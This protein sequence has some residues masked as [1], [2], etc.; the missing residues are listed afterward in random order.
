MKKIY[1]NGS[2]DFDATISQESAIIEQQK[3]KNETLQKE[4]SELEQFYNETYNHE[5][6]EITEADI[7]KELSFL[8]DALRDQKYEVYLKKYGSDDSMEE[9]QAYPL[10]FSEHATYDEQFARELADE[11]FF[12]NSNE[13]YVSRI[14]KDGQVIYSENLP[15]TFD[16]RELAQHL[17]QKFGKI[18]AGQ[19]ARRALGKS[20]SYQKDEAIYLSEKA[21][22]LGSVKELYE[23][24]AP[25]VYPQR[26]KYLAE[27]L[28]DYATEPDMSEDLFSTGLTY[29]EAVKLLQQAE[30]GVTVKEI[31]NY[32]NDW[33][34]QDI[35]LV[36]VYALCYFLL[37]FGKEKG[38]QIFEEK[39][40][41]PFEKEQ[42]ISYLDYNLSSVHSAKQFVE[43]I[44][45]EN[46]T[47]E[48]SQLGS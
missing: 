12:P 38:V 45:Q 10:Y 24:A 30:N 39:F 6:F 46:N 18:F 11:L 21:D 47:Y 9:K 19:Y 25:L 37:I 20:K 33:Q 48:R 14:V 36:D 42:N 4:N 8:R 13:H 5:F 43:Q 31:L 35:T 17:E 22:L 34:H 27:F 3:Q 40:I 26:Q 1:K 28:L 32:I 7:T 2:I 15:Q 23:K 29:K 41:K 16:K 44:R